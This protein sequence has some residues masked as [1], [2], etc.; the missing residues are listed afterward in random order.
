MR[1]RACDWFD[2]EGALR[3][4]RGEEPHSHLEGCLACSEAH[5]EYLGLV[6]LLPLAHAES[7]EQGRDLAR[8]VRLAIAS[9]LATLLCF[10]TGQRATLAAA[11]GGRSAP[12]GPLLAP[13]VAVVIAIGTGGLF[14]RECVERF[15]SASSAHSAPAPAIVDS[16]AGVAT[17]PVL[18]ASPTTEQP[19]VPRS[20]TVP[21]RS[22][23]A[24]AAPATP[25]LPPRPALAATPAVRSHPDP[26]DPAPAPSAKAR[27][28]RN[29]VMPLIIR[30]L[31]R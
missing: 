29:G 2:R 21:V 3:I 26:I 10:F 15:A 9:A 11:S 13:C 31:R 12:L 20:V 22:V 25:A 8:R 4:E 30:G 27:P 28:E 23:P 5:D 18:S 19:S 24:P 1:K 16:L 7:A 14:E 6:M 17:S